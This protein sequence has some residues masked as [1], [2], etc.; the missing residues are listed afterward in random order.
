MNDGADDVGGTNERAYAANNDSNMAKEVFALSFTP[1]DCEMGRMF[2]RN[3]SAVSSNVYVISIYLL[4][5][6]WNE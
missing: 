4:I 6:S 1:S 5:Y 3:V 2:D